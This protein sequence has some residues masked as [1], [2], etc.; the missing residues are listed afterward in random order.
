MR[1]IFKFSFSTFTIDYWP[2]L[3]F[4][5]LRILRHPS[6][7]QFV[8]LWLGIDLTECYVQQRL[9]CSIFFFLSL[10]VFKLKFCFDNFSFSDFLSLFGL[11]NLISSIFSRAI[12]PAPQHRRE[13]IN[14]NFQMWTSEKHRSLRITQKPTFSQDSSTHDVLHERRKKVADFLLSKKKKST[15]AVHENLSFTSAAFIL[16]TTQR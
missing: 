5:F 6:L 10:I 7:S 3:F 14:V 4:L 9:F 2:L 13:K 15:E 8:F 16:E 12:S 11:C 1:M